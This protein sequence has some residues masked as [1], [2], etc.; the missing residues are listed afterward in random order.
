MAAENPFLQLVT[1]EGDR[2]KLKQLYDEETGVVGKP[3]VPVPEDFTEPA[4]EA[5][6]LSKEEVSRVFESTFLLTV[7]D[8][9]LSITSITYLH[10]VCRL[11]ISRYSEECTLV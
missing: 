8:S 1:S 4:T 7:R 10:L 11:A 9:E 3:D 2:M 5:S 6:S